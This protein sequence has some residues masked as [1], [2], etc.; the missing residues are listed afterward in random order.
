[1]TVISSGNT[2]K[3]NK[4]NYNIG[5]LIVETCH[6]DTINYRVG[7]ITKKD[8]GTSY[9]FVYITWLDTGIEEAYLPNDVEAWIR[10]SY[11]KYY[12]IIKDEE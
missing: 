7:T 3:N 2:V 10:R 9:D 12:P 11:G 1:M 8:S 4:N 5:D 6:A